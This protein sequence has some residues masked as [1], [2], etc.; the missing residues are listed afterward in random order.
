MRHVDAQLSGDARGSMV[1]SLADLYI[2]RAESAGEE[3]GS[4]LFARAAHLMSD[5]LG[6]K[7]TALDIW[8]AGTVVWPENDDLL[9]EMENY[10]EA[11]G[12]LPAMAAH[13]DSLV[14]ETVDSDV[15]IRL[16]DRW[17][18]LL[19]IG[20]ED[21]DGAVEVYRKL[22]NLCPDDRDVARR[23]RRCLEH[24]GRHQEVLG[25]IRHE[26][27]R[28]THPRER[29][30]LLHEIAVL[31]EHDIQNRFEAMDAWRSVLTENPEHQEALEAL[32]RLG[33]STR[34][35][36]SEEMTP[37][38]EALLG[39]YD[40][41]SEFADSEDS[42]TEL[43]GVSSELFPGVASRLL[44]DSSHR[45]LEL[46]DEHSVSEHMRVVTEDTII[47]DEEEDSLVGLFAAENEEQT[48]R[49]KPPDSP[50]IEPLKSSPST[51]PPATLND[52]DAA[53][54]QASPS[55]V[56]DL[57]SDLV[58]LVEALADSDVIELE[59]GVLESVSDELA[60]DSDSLGVEEDQ[61]MVTGEHP[62]DPGSVPP[63][64]PDD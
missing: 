42:L 61:T 57:G 34:R 3:D 9:D 28:T 13:L 40:A 32:E 10:C 45:D 25:I 58:S 17:G 6:A 27:E 44:V 33:H 60:L 36:S 1:R 18:R 2:R 26:L 30:A 14:Q 23:L 8:K 62:R 5:A 49:E 29:V 59:S 24:Q 11:G 35:L 51:V 38:M 63:P 48:S 50:S 19:E 7:D 47:S 31:W 16:L 64:I 21:Y 46:D 43:D 55:G 56:V 52:A 20:I 53:N 39:P 54:F 15:A 22:L 37:S 41:T 12:E 4:R